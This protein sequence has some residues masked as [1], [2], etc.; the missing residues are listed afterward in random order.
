M[1]PGASA[2][3]ASPP[4]TR[5]DRKSTRLNSSHLGI[6]YAVFCLKKKNRAQAERS[7]RRVDPHVRP[8]SA[9]AQA[10]GA[11]AGRRRLVDGGARRGGLPAGGRAAH[12]RGW[13]RPA[14][15][16]DAAASVAYLPRAL[17]R[18]LRLGVRRLRAEGHP[19]VRDCGLA[20]LVAPPQ[21]AAPTFSIFFF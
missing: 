1:I 15:P 3:L 7:P 11:H 13:P 14:A 6:S 8:V 19:H 18:D 10:R 2:E 20:K 16:A 4:C 12:G 9:D 5:A 21:A 17:A